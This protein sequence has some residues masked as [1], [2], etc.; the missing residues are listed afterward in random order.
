[1]IWREPGTQYPPSN[2]IE[3]EHYA[4]GGLMV[5][6][7]IMQDTRTPLHVFD[8]GSMN[9]QRCRQEV[10]EPYVR[11]FRDAVGPEFLFMDDNAGEHRALMVGEHL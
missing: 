11:L 3:R 8:N 1:M 4:G 5:W 10:V 6:A 9:A 2:I 7:R